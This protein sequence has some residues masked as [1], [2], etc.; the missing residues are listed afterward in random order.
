VTLKNQKESISDT[1]IHLAWIY[2]IYDNLSEVK[3]WGHE[4]S[5]IV[6]P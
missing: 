3:A 1:T 5:G 2:E 4:S 6:T